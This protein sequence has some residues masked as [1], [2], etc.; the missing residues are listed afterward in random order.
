MAEYQAIYGNNNGWGIQQASDNIPAEAA[1]TFTDYSTTLNRSFAQYKDLYQGVVYVHKNDGKYAYHMVAT[2]DSSTDR[3]GRSNV[4]THGFIIPL[5][6]DPKMYAENDRLVSFSP[7]NFSDSLRFELPEYDLP[8][9]VFAEAMQRCDI[10]AQ[11]LER[12]VRCIYAILEEGAS[13]TLHIFVPDIE[14]VR[15]VMLCIYQVMPYSLRPEVSYSSV[16]MTDGFTTVTFVTP[17]FPAINRSPKTFDLLTGEENVLD[18]TT[19]SELDKHIGFHSYLC[20]CLSREENLRTELE[21]LDLHE[22]NLRSAGMTGIAARLDLLS[23]ILQMQRFTENDP[24]LTEKEMLMLLVRLL[25]LPQE[26]EEADRAL[27]DLIAYFDRNDTQLNDRVTASM[28]RKYSM[29]RSDSVRNA[30]F[31]YNCRSLRKLGKNEQ[32]MQLLEIYKENRDLFRLNIQSIKEH[33][34]SEGKADSADLLD[35]LYADYIGRMRRPETIDG[36]SA[37]CREAGEAEFSPH[38]HFDAFLMEQMLAA[39]TVYASQQSCSQAVFSPFWNQWLDLLSNL[40]SDENGRA[41]MT[42]FAKEAYWRAFD[43]SQFEE[44][45]M[46]FY[47]SMATDPDRA[48]NWKTVR[49]IIDLMRAEP[50][51]MSLRA[52]GTGSLSFLAA[53]PDEAARGRVIGMLIRHAKSMYGNAA[54]VDEWMDF[55]RELTEQDSSVNNPYTYVFEAEITPLYENAAERYAESS[56]DKLGFAEYQRLLKEYAEQGG[57]YSAKALETADVLKAVAKKKFGALGGLFRRK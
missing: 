47:R 49:S 23:L 41:E 5:A 34:K 42:A 8:Y 2:N 33:D 40:V 52:F 21:Y 56:T 11:K 27:C 22:T 14:Y 18:A 35:T 10:S 51:Q 19:E 3:S 37:I 12:L 48:P 45:D 29:T 16:P 54:D 24:S 4:L 46:E 9:P 38:P 6:D 43:I 57:S 32:C 17:D 7:D 39:V 15:D 25:N 50:D 55:L 53:I 44:A 1:K 30:I 26:S 28:Q 31:L 20:M 36:I 13:E